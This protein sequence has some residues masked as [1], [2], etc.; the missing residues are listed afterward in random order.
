MIGTPCEKCGRRRR[1]ELRSCER[2]S[3]VS[4]A[5]SSSKTDASKQERRYDHPYLASSFVRVQF[6]IFC[7]NS[8]RW[9]APPW[10]LEGKCTIISTSPDAVARISRTSSAAPKYR[11]FARPYIRSRELYAIL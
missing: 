5:T 10:A 1:R 7:F 3:T 11:V 6:S 4:F 2:Q 8:S 9:R